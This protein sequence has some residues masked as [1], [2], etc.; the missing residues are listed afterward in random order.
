MQESPLFHSGQEYFFDA[1]ILMDGEEAPNDRCC[2]ICGKIGHFVRDCPRKR[3]KK[4]HDD[5]ESLL[6][7]CNYVHQLI[8]D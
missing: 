4:Q 3:R 2:R 1:K 5:D 8:M 7:F 6:G